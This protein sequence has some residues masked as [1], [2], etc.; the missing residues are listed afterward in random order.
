M[1]MITEYTKKYTVRNGIVLCCINTIG[2]TDL[3]GK[4]GKFLFSVKIAVENKELIEEF[5]DTWD[6]GHEAGK[7][8]VQKKIKNILN[9]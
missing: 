8:D 6:K 5:L 9:L 2:R 4:R 3:Y 7:E 1:A